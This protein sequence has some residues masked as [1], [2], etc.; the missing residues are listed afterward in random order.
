M[1]TFV[2]SFGIKCPFIHVLVISF[3]SDANPLRANPVARA[4]GREGRMEGLT[5]L[6]NG[7]WQSENAI[8]DSHE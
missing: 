3:I 7:E 1:D 6:W 5:F 4:G 2:V 8:E